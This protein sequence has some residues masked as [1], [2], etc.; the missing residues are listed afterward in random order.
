LLT[1]PKRP[2]Y[3]ILGGSK[4]TDKIATIESLMTKVNGLLIGGAMAH[5]FWAAQRQA[6]PEGGQAT[7]AGTT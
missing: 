6:D 5:A 3:A 2:F 7:Q 1:E 4:V